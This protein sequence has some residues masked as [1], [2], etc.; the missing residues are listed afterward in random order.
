MKIKTK[1]IAA[2][3][4]SLSLL[5][6]A[7]CGALDQFTAPKETVTARPTVTVTVPEGYTV[8]QIAQ[9][10]EEK[11]VCANT[12]FIAAVNDPPT[13]NTFAAAITNADQRPFLLEGYVFPD[14]Y[15]F[16]TNEPAQKVLGKF[17]SNM[18]TKLT[19]SD[20]MRAAELGYTMDDILTI[21]SLI[22]AEAGFKKWDSLVSSVIYNRLRSDSYPF[23][24]LD[25][26]NRYIKEDGNPEV[27]AYNEK[28][29]KYYDT[30]K[31]KKLPAGPICNP[32]RDAIIAA[33]NPEETGFYFYCTDL[34][35]GIFYFAVTYD[36]HKVNLKK[37]GITTG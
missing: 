17:L 24:Q 21:A 29:A 33:L 20:Y 11:G 6:L 8:Y 13:D 30:Y 5:Y 34:K 22:Q 25:A 9:L 27:A 3:V 18:K 16:Y 31:C 1:I 12:D 4:V 37:A 23:L 15:E 19:D 26:T 2:L 14:T 10:L 36:E 7:G 32:G 28:F 35:T